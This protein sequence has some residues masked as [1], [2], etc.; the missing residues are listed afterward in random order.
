ML[1]LDEV[2]REIERNSGT[3]FDENLA[4]VFLNLDLHQLMRQF[5]E[6]PTTVCI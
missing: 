2:R 1:P 6:R 3:Q 5:L 4:K